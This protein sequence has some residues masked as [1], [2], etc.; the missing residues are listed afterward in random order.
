[1][2]ERIKAALV[3]IIGML[4][5]VIVFILLR[6]G[7]Q[8]LPELTMWGNYASLFNIDSIPISYLDLIYFLL[9]MVITVHGAVNLYLITL[10]NH[11]GQN[12]ESRKPQTLLKTGVYAKA[13]HP[14]YGTFM[15][16]N[17]G[18]FISTRSLWGILVIVFFFTIQY[19]NAIFEEKHELIEIFGDEYRDYQKEVENKFFLP[20]YRVY[21]WIGVVLTVGGIF[22]IFL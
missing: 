20:A 3:G 13:R 17:L 9:G 22:F 1:M 12:M 16:I 11:Q 15:I 10:E 21:L 14:M 4:V 7:L 19:F 5:Y 2:S 6:I 18:L 8:Y